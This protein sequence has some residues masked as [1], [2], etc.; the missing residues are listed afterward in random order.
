[1]TALREAAFYEPLGDGAVRCTLCPDACR[2]VDGRRGACGVRY[3]EGGVHPRT[4]PWATAGMRS[5]WCGVGARIWL[6][7]QDRAG[8]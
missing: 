2:I 8:R 4:A 6:Y 1:M 7:R 5:A 3:N